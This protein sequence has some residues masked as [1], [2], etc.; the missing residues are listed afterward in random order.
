[1]FH[2]VT[3]ATRNTCYYHFAMS[4]ADAAQLSLMK[5]YL[6]QT[7]AEDIDASESIEH[8]L[9]V[10]GAPVREVVS[11]VIAMLCVAVCCCRR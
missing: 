11:S 9:S 4:S 8:M 1:V 2:A 5:E 10:Q 3:P 6:K 7:V